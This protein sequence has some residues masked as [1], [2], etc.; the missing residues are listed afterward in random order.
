MDILYYTI[1][2]LI[3][4][5]FSHVVDMSEY[6]GLPIFII[7]SGFA[8]GGDFIANDTTM[9]LGLKLFIGKYALYYSMMHVVLTCV[10]MV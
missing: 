7:C 4:F 3:G 5:A 9:E 10:Y 2:Y 8:V 6:Y 1:C